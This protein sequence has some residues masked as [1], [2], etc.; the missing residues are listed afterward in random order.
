[1]LP[2]PPAVAAVLPSL[3]DA[4]LAEDV[5]TGDITTEATIPAGTR[6][7]ARFLLK[8]DGVVA[9][10]AVAERVFAA[11]DAELRVSWT[12]SDGD[13]LESG[14]VF[15]GVAGRAR[16]ILVAERLALNLMQRMGGIAT[17]AYAMAAAA[18]PATVLDTRKTAPG[19]R[20]LDKWAVRLGGADNHRIGLFD[21]VL[22]KD[23]HIA[24]TGGVRPALEAVTRHLAETGRDVPVEIET[25]SLDEIDAVLDAQTS[26]SRVDRVLLDNFARRGP[27]G[28]VDVAPLREA[29][30]RVAGRVQT[31]ASG[32]VTLDTIGAI[33]ATGV[34]FVSTGALTHSVRAL[35]ISLKI[36]LDAAS[37]P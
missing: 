25:R 6:A 16:S 14:T 4:A 37:M 32:N 27:D 35:D 21:M 36:D 13:V 11:V 12:A 26:G 18:A 34:D 2:L 9:G 24:A 19:L 29:V 33:G 10:L 8:A 1:M 30:A 20:A 17:L 31:E 23:N 22:V 5:G 3:I 7:E 28:A 15:G